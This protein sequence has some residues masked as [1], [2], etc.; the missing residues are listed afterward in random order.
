MEPGIW[1]VPVL[2]IASLIIVLLNDRRKEKIVRK[3]ERQGRLPPR[4]YLNYRQSWGS[5]LMYLLCGLAVLALL[6]FAPNIAPQALQWT[7]IL[8]AGVIGALVIL[9]IALPFVSRRR[10]P[11]VFR[12]NRLAHNGDVQGAIALLREHLR[13]QRPT[14]LLYGNLAAYHAMLGQWEECLRLIHEAELL[15]DGPPSLL[16]N[17][18]M[19]LWKL[20]RA[21]E[22][23][24]C[25]E[26]AVRR[27]PDNLF[28]ICNYG[29][30]LLQLGRLA[31]ALE[32]L[33]RADSLFSNDAPS[34]G[35]DRQARE[36]AL[37][38]FRRRVAD[39]S[40]HSEG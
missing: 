21:E 16:A 22:A 31:E 19:A 25:F 26:E 20:G 1:I 30:L 7:H 17:K 8:V 40:T 9:S 32:Q 37:E 14:A 28:R 39:S 24:P 34:H 13:E 5:V 2:L 33:R 11:V 15:G 27:D 3:A 23:L 10:H 4:R 12:A 35:N 38:D 29:S 18:G 36:R 6:V